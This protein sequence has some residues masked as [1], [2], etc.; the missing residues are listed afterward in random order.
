MEHESSGS[1]WIILG[2]I[3][4]AVTIGYIILFGVMLWM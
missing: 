2:P 1:D 3:L 4:M